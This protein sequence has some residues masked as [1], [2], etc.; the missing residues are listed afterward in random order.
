M[1]YPKDLLGKVATRPNL[2]KA[3]EDIS[4]A[5][6]PLSHGPSEQTIQDFRANAEANL[7]QIRTELLKGLFRFGRL[8]AVTIAKKG[9]KKR[10]L[11]IADIRDRV[12]Q[13]AITRQLEAI[14]T[15]QFRLLNPASH[16]YLPGRGVQSAY[17]RLLHFHREGCGVVFEADIV[18][19]F[20]SVDVQALLGSMI[21]PLLRDS[22]LND[23]V[24]QAFSM[25]IDNLN[26]LPEEDWTL[27]PES[28]TGLPQG[29]Y[30][31][32]LFSN[33][34][35]S[36]FDKK[37]LDANLRLVR[38]A[39]DFVVM[40]RT[41]EEAER[42]YFISRDILENDLNLQLH[43]RD[44]ANLTGRTR[45]VRPTQT[46]IQFLGI[47]FNGLRIW[48]TSEKRQELSRKLNDLRR[49]G[50]AKAK[51]VLTLLSSTRNLIEGW[52]ASYSFTDVNTTYAE[53]LDQEVNKHLWSAL[54]A[55]GWKLGG[56]RLSQEQR[57]RS[58]VLQVDTFLVRAR[59]RLKDQE[60]WKE[61]WT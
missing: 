19:F 26:D 49:S 21:F 48:P 4:R 2:R 17:R 22:T 38:Y 53:K 15:N 1:A 10:P 9:G 60:L 35:L 56:D 34:Y 18:N 41:V 25:E 6:K 20:D 13:R 30:L 3:W 31:S 28:S 11:R 33:I 39:D 55:M 42:A 16:A 29:G 36:L 46:T 44:D 51:N 14:C 37:M 47:Q 61:Y 45:V 54:S 32:P 5:A 58:G 52:V 40:C 59:S 43:P 50:N 8:R 23:L 27:F 12:V 7:E 57:A 24:E